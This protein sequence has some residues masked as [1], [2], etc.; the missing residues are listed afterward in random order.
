[1]TGNSVRAFPLSPLPPQGSPSLQKPP[2]KTKSERASPSSAQVEKNSERCVCSRALIRMKPSEAMSY[3]FAVQ[4][5]H[6]MSSLSENEI[7]AHLQQL[8]ETHP[9]AQVGRIGAYSI[10][11]GV[12]DIFTLDSGVNFQ[13]CTLNLSRL[14]PTSYVLSVESPCGLWRIPLLSLSCEAQLDRGPGR[15]DPLSSFLPITR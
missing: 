9:R 12:L 4:I 6:S 3:P 5:P 7:K 1:M 14:S 11:S 8:R 15:S 13:D 10:R 2:E